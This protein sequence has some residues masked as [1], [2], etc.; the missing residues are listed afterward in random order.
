M[1]KAF[2]NTVNTIQATLIVCLGAAFTILVDKSNV[3]TFKL[4]L[5]LHKYFEHVV[6]DHT[7]DRLESLRV[8]IVPQ[9]YGVNQLVLGGG[10]TT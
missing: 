8:A 5:R 7:Q 3:V 1:P 2:F 6:N 4:P 10:D 9:E